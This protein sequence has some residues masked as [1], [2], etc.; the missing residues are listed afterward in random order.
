VVYPLTGSTAYEREMSTPPIQVWSM[1][2][3][4]LLR[5]NT[6]L[7]KRLRIF[8]R[9]FFSQANQIPGQLGGVGLLH[10]SSVYS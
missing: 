6:P 5:N 10:K 9:C 4:Y 7:G 8:S 3:L 2:L 1:A